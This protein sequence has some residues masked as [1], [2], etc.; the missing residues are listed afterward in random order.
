MLAVL[1]LALLAKMILN[2]R[3]YQYGFVLA[4][5]C[6]AMLVAALV[7]LLPQALRRIGG[8]ATV[9]RW[10]AVGLVAGLIV[11]RMVL[12][13]KVL[14][15]RTIE[16]PLAMGGQ[17]Y[18][19]P[20]DEPAAEAVRWLGNLPPATTAAI[21]PDAAGIDFAAGKASGVRF[22]VLNPMTIGMWGEASILGALEAHPPDVIL[23]VRMDMSE[24]GGQWFGQDYGRQVM[25]W[26]AAGYRPTEAFGPADESGSIEAWRRN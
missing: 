21:Y 17:L 12:T 26:I 20:R 1:S 24:L 14:S 23:I 8:S 13:N 18:G 15:E 25:R 22:N 4:A 5:P 7:D 10:G 19:R 2:V 9:A 16:I 3:T 6:G 11:N